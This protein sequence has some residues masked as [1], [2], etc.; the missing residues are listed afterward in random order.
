LSGWTIILIIMIEDVSIAEGLIF[1][2]FVAGFLAAWAVLIKRKQDPRD[3]GGVAIVRTMSGVSRYVFGVIGLAGLGVGIAIQNGLLI[4]AG[5][6]FL[7]G[8]AGQEWVNR[9]TRGR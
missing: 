3:D 4:A 5:V 1:I 2:A 7:L 9:G 8:A 6:M